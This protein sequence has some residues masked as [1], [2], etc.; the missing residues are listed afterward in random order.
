MAE[1]DVTDLDAFGNNAERVQIRRIGEV[2]K[3]SS[4][5]ASRFGF[6]LD[7]RSTLE[8]LLVSRK[9]D[10]LVVSLHGALDR[11]KTILPRFERLATLL[12]GNTSSLFLSDPGLVLNPTLE[13]GWFT[14]WQGYELYSDLATL[15]QSAARE[16]DAKHIVLSGSSGG[17]F[18]ALQLAT[19]IP[20]SIAL[21]FNPQTDIHRYWNNG[22]PNSHGAVRKYIEVLYPDAAPNGIWKI[23]WSVDWTVQYGDLHSPVRRYLKRQDCRVVYVNNTKDFHYE[24]HFLPFLESLKS[25]RQESIL[26]NFEYEGS[27]GHHPPT[28]E[29]FRQGLEIAFGTV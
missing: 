27:I 13:L 16:V 20:K 25:S 2:P 22:D 7:S 9:S 10:Y 3:C 4:G 29:I 5:T 12:Q 23:D 19:Y 8:A 11:K 18:A 17:G 21:V 1:F 15:I 6:D 14:G 28:P 26:T 24:Q